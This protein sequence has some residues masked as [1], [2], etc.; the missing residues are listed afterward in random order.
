MRLRWGSR[1]EIIDMADATKPAGAGQPATGK[2][3]V[4]NVGS[5]PSAVQTTTSSANQQKG[6]GLEVSVVG[7][8]SGQEGGGQAGAARRQGATQ[9]AQG[10]QPNDGTQRFI[11]GR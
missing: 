8:A 1:D 9:P 10:A 7:T 4:I 5:A 6:S 2:V 3:T 11:E